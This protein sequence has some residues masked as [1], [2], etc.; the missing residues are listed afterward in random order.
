VIY[1][2]VFAALL[3]YRLRAFLPKAR[4]NTAAN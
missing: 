4:R 3:Y 1:G 2:V